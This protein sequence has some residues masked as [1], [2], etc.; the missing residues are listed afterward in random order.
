[1][2][3]FARAHK[4][5]QHVFHERDRAGAGSHASAEGLLPVGETRLSAVGHDR[6]HA[7]SRL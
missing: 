5:R 3:R 6:Q 2:C 4:F 1:M 7:L